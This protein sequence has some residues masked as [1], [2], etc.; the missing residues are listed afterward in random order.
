M[1]VPQFVEETEVLRVL[2]D[3]VRVRSNMVTLLDMTGAIDIDS[4]MLSSGNERSDSSCYNSPLSFVFSDLSFFYMITHPF[5][6][7]GLLTTLVFIIA[8]FHLLPRTSM[9]H[10]HL[11]ICTSS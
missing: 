8:S 5:H 4:S 7:T 2:K 3:V 10:L 6:V 11:L 9:I 1:L